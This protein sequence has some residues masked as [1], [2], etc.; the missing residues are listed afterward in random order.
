MSITAD[1]GVAVIRTVLIG[2]ADSFTLR[3][4]HFLAAMDR[5]VQTLMLS[6]WA[7]FEIGVFDDFDVVFLSPGHWTR[8]S[9]RIS[10]YAPW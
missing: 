5:N 6:Y 10:K 9:P 7:E 8:T 4:V 1:E 2:D 3:H